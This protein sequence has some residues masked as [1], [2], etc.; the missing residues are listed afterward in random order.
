MGPERVGYI[1]NGS[2]AST[3]SHSSRRTAG[4][5]RGGC[6]LVDCQPTLVSPTTRPGRRY[7]TKLLHT[8]RPLVHV[9]SINK[10]TVRHLLHGTTFNTTGFDD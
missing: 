2:A 6:G 7:I 10:P 9:S 1:V 5:L 3:T 8:S 4:E